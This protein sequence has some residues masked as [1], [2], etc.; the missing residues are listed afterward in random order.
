VYSAEGQFSNTGFYQ[1]DA[2]LQPGALEEPTIKAQPASPLGT[3]LVPD[4]TVRTIFLYNEDRMRSKYLDDPEVGNLIG[5]LQAP[6]SPLFTASNGIAINL[7]SSAQISVTNVNALNALYDQWDPQLPS[8]S[9]VS[10]SYGQPLLANE[11]A[12]QIWY[13]LDRAITDYYTGTTDLVLVGG[14]NII[15]QYRIPDETAIANEGDYYNELNATGALLTD[16]PLAGSL[17]FHFVQTDNFY[18]DRQPTPWRGR[19]LYIPDMGVGRLVESPTDIMHYLNAYSPLTSYLIKADAANNGAALVTGYDFLTD[20][21]IAISNTLESYGFDPNGTL[22]S[23]TR[24]DT[25]INDTWDTNQ[26]TDLWFTGQ[27]PRLTDTYCSQ[28][29]CL[30]GPNTRYNLMSING[31]FSHYDAIPADPAG[32]TFL[33]QRLLTPTLDASAPSPLHAYFMMPLTASASLVYS[34]GCHSGLSVA[35]SDIDVDHPLYQADWPNAALKQGGN[36][37]GNTGYGYGDSDLVGYS[38]RLSLLFTQAIGRRIGVR[39][40][41]AGA[42]LG[43][44]LARAKREYVRTSAPL[45]F[46]VYDEKV[47]SEMTLYGLP[48]IR[49]QVPNPTPPRYANASFDPAPAKVP[50]ST[51]VASGVFTRIITFT[52]TFAPLAAGMPPEATSKVQDSFLPGVTTPVTSEH[53]MAIGRPVLPALTYDITLLPRIDGGPIP[54]PKGVRLLRATTLP[55]LAGV[56]PHVTT[57][58]SDTVYPQ[59]QDDPPLEIRDTWLPDQPYAY[60]RNTRVVANQTLFQDSLVVNPAQFR[61]LNQETGQQRRFSQMVFEVSY[62]DP[63]ATGAISDNLPPRI[64]TIHVAPPAA[65][66][67]SIAPAA[68]S[69]RISARVADNH[70][71]GL[72]VRAAYTADGQTW[73]SVKLQPTA[74]PAAGGLFMA[75]IDAPANSWN[76]F[77]IVEARD[78]SGNVTTDTAKGSLYSFNSIFMPLVRH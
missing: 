11:V 26:L 14:D 47:I 70:V 53:Q 36:W 75:N 27:L 78:R 19:A 38:E 73:K 62:L 54:E 57:P 2:A 60:Q 56:D 74:G 76:I 39:A 46:S 8:I 20:Q 23:S 34:V 63:S 37:I 25:L 55:D 40:G 64:D 50:S 42:P 1:L 72:D 32:E 5:L 3:A 15:P 6:G 51:P 24:L 49:V 12:Q 44:S 61:A 29:A 30:G 68:Q 7:S 18:A 65:T 28:Q 71:G 31:H 52:N 4:S 21:A 35:D 33:A 45:G 67:N 22:G 59:Q 48:F 77:V 13:I 58:V 43:E 66:T 9:Q 69:I 10:S 16:S 17:L 41:Y